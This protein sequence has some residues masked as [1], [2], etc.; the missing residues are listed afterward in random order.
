MPSTY[1]PVRGVLLFIGGLLA[2]FDLVERER[3]RRATD[4]S[5][6]RIVTGLARMSK[7]TVDVAMVGLALGPTAIAGVGFAA[8]FWEL[9]F[10]L[11]GGVAGGTI[12]MVSQRYGADA[13]AELA[14]T[15]TTSAAVALGLTLPLLAAYWVLP[16]LL[17]DLVG[18]GSE[19]VDYGVQYL[20]V[21]ALGV[22][23]AALNLIASRTLVGADDA[24]TP[25]LL[26][27]GGA[28]VNIALNAV[29]IFGFG[30]GVVGAALGTVVANVLV[31]AGF[32][33]GLARGGLPVIGA[34][35][36]RIPLSRP[37]LD[38][39]LGRD[40]AE[41][42]APLVGANLARTGAQFPRLFIV[43]LFGP[44]VV[45]AYVVALRVRALLDTPNWG[46]SLASSSLV[47]QALGEGNEAEAT[48]WAQ[49][50]LRLSIGVYIVVA[51]TLLPFS[52]G[53]ARLFVSDPT[54]LP[55]VTVFVA[56]ACASVVFRGVDG[57]S[58]G[59][60]RASGDTRWPLYSQLAGMYLFAL[61]L[62]YLGYVTP[63]GELALYASL[64]V[65]TAVP[66][67]VTYYRFRSGTWR[68]VSRSYRPD[69]AL[70]D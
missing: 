68:V 34:F 50:V 6:P 49:T 12:G 46:L 70:D 2:R 30:L 51:A 23:F 15:V 69:A 25:M 43:G 59:P 47:G 45:S 14:V 9:V 61:P 48:V 53:L 54:V 63:L 52:R 64:V 60:L 57:G 1:N 40:L 32:A 8:P 16:G 3:I 39:G 13:E 55:L 31:T 36:V 24:W 4:L 17:V 18:T 28:V 37:F 26:R 44:G 5:W 20:R 66:A 11:G 62:A 67:A 33:V 21:I 29:F 22:P 42:G 10:A 7:S 19:A 56:V 38:R 65:E 27:A 41:T 35:P 58:T